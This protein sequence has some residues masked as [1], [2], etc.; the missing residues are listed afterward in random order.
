MKL[1]LNTTLLVSF[2]LFSGCFHFGESG[3]SQDFLELDNGSLHLKLDLTRGGAIA[4]LSKSG[5]ERNLI[6]IHDGGR[7]V[8]QSYYAGDNLD[9]TGDG[10]SRRWSPW[11]WNPIQVGDAFNNR[12][13]ILESNREGNTLYVKCIPMLWDMNNK[14]AEAIMEQW[15]TLEGTFLKVH[16]KLTCMRTDSIYGEGELRDQELPA[17]YPISALNHLYTYFG[18]NP[19]TEAP[20]SKPQVKHLEDDFWGR[21]RNGI[22]TENWMAFVND[23]KWGMAVYT[24]TCTDFL[25]GM[26]GQPGGEAKDRSTSYIAPIKREKLYINSVYEYDYYLLIGDLEVMRAQIYQLNKELELP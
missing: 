26:A 6:N 13:K 18:D 20:L 9:R 25:A 2:L 19:F 24:P 14:P 10:Q 5:E 4:Y 17:V 3:I 21:Y 22:V 11:S 8:Q 16:N 1:I 15:T 12:A 23:E 7:Y